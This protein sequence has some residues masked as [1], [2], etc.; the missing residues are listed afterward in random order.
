MNSQISCRD[1]YVL[2]REEI[3]RELVCRRGGSWDKNLPVCSSTRTF[4]ICPKD[5]K[6]SLPD[7]SSTIW[8]N[9]NIVSSGEFT[10][11]HTPTRKNGQKIEYLFGE[12]IHKLKFSTQSKI[13]AEIESCSYTVT[14]SDT[15][16]PRAINCPNQVI[17]HKD[18]SRNIE[19]D[20][21]F[22]DNTGIENRDND[23]NN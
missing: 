13:T 20:P 19:I 8:I 7:A 2:K 1:G 12:G 14:I 9:I 17:R 3:S 23:F 21:K 5:A 10:T 16:P 11:S 18:L 15:T 4:I 22:T 6:Y